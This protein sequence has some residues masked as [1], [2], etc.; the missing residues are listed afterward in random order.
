M[1]ASIG[2]A[3]GYVGS[4]TRY[5]RL[6]SGDIDKLQHLAVSTSPIRLPD[7][8]FPLICCWNC[9]VEGN[10][11]IPTLFWVWVGVGGS[12]HFQAKCGC[13]GLFSRCAHLLTFKKNQGILDFFAVKNRQI[14]FA[15][16]ILVGY[17]FEGGARKNGQFVS[18][19][20][21]RFL[22][23]GKFLSQSRLHKYRCLFT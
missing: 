13:G 17:V 22:K 1:S 9:G 14:F 20:V 10:S 15:R 23:S 18:L 6:R 3:N 7:Q 5:E 2:E 12:A 21:W 16:E 11:L 4:S 8:G 19:C